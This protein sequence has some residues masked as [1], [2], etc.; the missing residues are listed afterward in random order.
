MLEKLYIYGSDCHVQVME[1]LPD[2]AFSTSETHDTE[3]QAIV[4][5]GWHKSTT[6][7]AMML[8]PRLLSLEVRLA[9]NL[10]T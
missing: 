7:A 8:P 10:W 5:C 9:P 3:T 6:E 4:Q 1:L 2:E